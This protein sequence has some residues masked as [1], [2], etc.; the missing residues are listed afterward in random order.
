M[1]KYSLVL[2]TAAAILF[3]TGCDDECCGIA[4]PEA[5]VAAGRPLPARERETA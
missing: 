2:L 1:I 3:S 5:N 4:T